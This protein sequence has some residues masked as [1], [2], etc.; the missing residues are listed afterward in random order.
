MSAH[1]PGDWAGVEYGD[2]YYEIQGDHRHLARVAKGNSQKEG[3]ANA[4]VMAAGPKLFEALRDACNLLI[5]A[6]ACL[7]HPEQF[8]DDMSQL[9]AKGLR[10]WEAKTGQPVID[11]AE[12][13][14][15]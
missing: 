9:I 3:L 11:K 10:E 7:E 6:A 2:N 12:G 8:G 13:R 15:V 5:G 1:T 4:H 14:D